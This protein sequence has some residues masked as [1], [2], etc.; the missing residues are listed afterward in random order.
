M[1]RPELRFNKLMEVCMLSKMIHP[2]GRLCVERSMRSSLLN[3]LEPDTVQVLVHTRAATKGSPRQNVNNHPMYA[4]S[5]AVVHN[6]VISNDD[7]LFKTLKL[8]RKAET[9]SDIL[10]AIVDEHGITPEGIEVLGKVKGSA[11][12]ACLSPDFPNKM[13]ISAVW[14]ASA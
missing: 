4:G 13:L 6:G 9:D 7:E 1:M 14:V 8:D 5:A 11:A 12:I 2:R 10:R 3:N